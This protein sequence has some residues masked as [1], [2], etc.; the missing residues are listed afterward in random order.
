VSGSTG[1]TIKAPYK[2][3]AAG[4]SHT[5][6]RKADG[7]LASWGL[8]RSG[9]LG[10]GTSVDRVVPTAVSGAST[11]WSGIA[12]GDFHSLSVRTDGSLWAWGFNQ[13]GQLGDKTY[14]D[15]AIPTAVGTVKTWASVSAGKAHSIGVMKDGTL[16]AWGRNFDGQIGDATGADKPAPVQVLMT[17]PSATSTTTTATAADKIWTAAWAG[18]NFSIGRKTDSTLFSWGGNERGQLGR[19][20]AATVATASNT[21]TLVAPKPA[22]ATAATVAF[23]ALTV[24]VGSYHVLAIRPDGALFVWGANDQGQ[25]GDG[26]ISDRSA[27]TQVGTETDWAAIAAGGLHSLAIK[28]DG[29]LWTWGSNSDGQLGVGT[30]TDAWEPTQIGLSK[31]WV[32][33][34]AGKAHSFGLKSDGTLWG[35]GRNAEGQLGNG[36]MTIKPVVVPTQLQ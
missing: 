8:N 6:V 11:V 9:Q 21:P 10:D 29:T 32:A 35:W 36:A 26:T 13:N 7:T 22:T 4:G 14:V 30:T 1:I 5:L 20:D 17:P 28:A 34:S 12:A 18:A 25:L 23:K 33:I 15:K 27:A 24:S 19:G 31:D 16:W 2:A 3:V